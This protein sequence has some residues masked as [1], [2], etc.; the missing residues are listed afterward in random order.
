MTVDIKKRDNETFIKIVGVL[1]KTTAESLEKTIYNSIKS[2]PSI[3]LDL[4]GIEY[5]TKDGL[6]V[7][8]RIRR[9][10]KSVGSLRLEGVCESVMQ[11]IEASGSAALAA[12]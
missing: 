11:I 10:I 8:L 3:T 1:D 9:K 6:V 2:A 12:E 4:N 5:I 7:L